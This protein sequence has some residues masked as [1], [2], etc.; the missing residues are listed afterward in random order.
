MKFHTV[1]KSSMDTL[2]KAEQEG[3]PAILTACLM[4]E[5]APGP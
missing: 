3:R 1:H 4:S 5:G 2:S